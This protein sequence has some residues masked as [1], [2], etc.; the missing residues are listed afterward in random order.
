MQS[1]GT[2][3][4]TYDLFI[5]GRNHL[6]QKMNKTNTQYFAINLSWSKL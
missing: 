4:R 1:W 2:T 5:E 6:Q 3:D